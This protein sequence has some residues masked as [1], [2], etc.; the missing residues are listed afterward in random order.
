MPDCPP[1]P[2]P[3][4]AQILVGDIG[5]TNSRLALAWA[6]GPDAGSL[7]HDSLARLTNDDHPSLQALIGHYLRASGAP[8]ALAGAVLAVAGPLGQGRAALTN[9]DWAITETALA[10]I[11]GAPQAQ[12]LNDLQAQGHALAALQARGAGLAPLIARPRDPGGPKLVIGLGTGLNA[13]VVHPLGQ[14]GGFLGGP[15]LVTASETGHISAPLRSDEDLALA[16]HIGARI[17]GYVSAEELLSGRGIAAIDD[18]LAQRDAGPPGR[19]PA[20]IL[21]DLAQDEPRARAVMQ[22]Y[23]RLLGQ[24]IGDLALIHLPHGGIALTGGVAR[25]LAPW[26]HPFGLA[27]AIGDKGRFGDLAAGFALD[28][29]TDDFAALIG[30]AARA[31]QA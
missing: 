5:G 24:V 30:C 20:Q 19:A 26:F 10:Q 27:E 28:L 9:R 1:K 12:L 15:N 22:I 29:V 6:E 4:P 2:T 18:F 25:H 8:R 3:L 16:R 11:A 7:C 17:Q 14:G 31:R 23:M 13:A 21:A